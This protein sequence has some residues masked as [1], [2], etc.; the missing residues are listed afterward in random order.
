M[1]SNIKLNQ[2]QGLLV[3][4]LDANKRKFIPHISFYEFSNNEEC[5]LLNLLNNT[6][7]RGAYKRFDE[8]EFKDLNLARFGAEYDS[9]GNFFMGSDEFQLDEQGM[10]QTN[11]RI[12]SYKIVS[13]SSTAP[14]LPVPAICHYSFSD[15]DQTLIPKLLNEVDQNVL[16]KSIREIRENLEITEVLSRFYTD[17]TIMLKLPN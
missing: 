13:L 8:N 3:L 14:G 7:Y 15:V 12:R 5:Y 2:Y 4:R 9:P 6:L 1:P 10:V 11:Q 17:A 16:N